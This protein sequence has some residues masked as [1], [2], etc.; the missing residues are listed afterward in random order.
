VSRYSAGGDVNG[1][2]V[3]SILMLEVWLSSFLPRARAA[4]VARDRTLVA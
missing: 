2:L 3:L 4:S 1:Q